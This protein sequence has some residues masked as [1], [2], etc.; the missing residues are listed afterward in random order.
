VVKGMS[1]VPFTMTTVLQLA[2][3]TL[4]PVAPL[5]LTIP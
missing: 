1:V 5:M 3:T 2:V 4:L